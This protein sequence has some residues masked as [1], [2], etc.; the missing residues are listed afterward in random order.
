MSP[1]AWML[2]AVVMIGN[3]AGQLL[4]KAASVRADRAGE[5]GHWRALLRDPLL[6]LGVA[7][8]A[9]EFF[10]WL[11]F[12]SVVPL[13]LGVMV[14]CIDIP[15]VMLGGRVLFGERISPARAGAISLIAV[16]VAMVGLGGN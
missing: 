14:A 7:T 13:W 11:A 8:Y 5:D 12:L 9:I 2:L 6:W 16:G 3:T 1:L 4:L 15:L 10:V